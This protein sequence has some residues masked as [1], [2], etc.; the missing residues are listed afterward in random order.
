MKTL[1]IPFTILC[2][3]AISALS[4]HAA[5]LA[6]AKVLKVEGTVTK[7]AAN[8]KSS[9]IK[10]GDILSQGDSISTTALSS[11][12]IVF[13]NGSEVSVLEN[14]SVDIAKLQ[15]DSFGGSQKYEQLQAD[16]SQSHTLLELNYGKL[17]GHV[18]KL[19]P[20]ST[21]NIETP[22]GTAA[23][24]GTQFIVEYS[25]DADLGEFIVRVTNIDGIVGFTAGEDKPES[26]PTEESA[27]RATRRGQ[28]ESIPV[29]ESATRV[30]RRG[31]PG[32]DALLNA[33]ADVLPPEDSS[34]FIELNDAE[35]IEDLDIIVVSP[36]GQGE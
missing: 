22:L 18:K 29:G 9:P 11:T 36:E 1:R 31:D 23:I 28:P 35:I 34:E 21:F 19:Q 17:L 13:S 5:Q 25:Y 20:G 30:I 3:L 2:A 7:L 4:S 33:V 27:D 15:Q 14:S 6:S 16:P 8:G 32:Y 24:R 26:I 12:M 10:A